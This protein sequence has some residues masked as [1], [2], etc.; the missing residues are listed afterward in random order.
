M[1]FNVTE[2]CRRLVSEERHLCVFKIIM[3][4]SNKCCPASPTLLRFNYLSGGLGSMKPVPEE[5]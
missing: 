3:I 4:N 5:F 2:L 1:P